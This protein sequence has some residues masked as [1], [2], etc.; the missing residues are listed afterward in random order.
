MKISV[1]NFGPIGEAKDIHLSPMTL[2]V[3]PSNTGKSYLAILLYAIAETF[4]RNLSWFTMAKKYLSDQDVM[5]KMI[6]DIEGLMSSH[7]KESDNSM[8]RKLYSDW[9]H[10]ISEIWREKILYCFGEEGENLLQN[11]NLSVILRSDD[12]TLLIDLVSPQHSRFLPRLQSEIIDKIPGILPPNFMQQQDPEK[13]R[14]FIVFGFIVGQFHTVL[15]DNPFLSAHYL[16]AIRGGIMQSHRGLV[17][18]TM[19]QAPFAGLL[20]HSPRTN[21][22]P[23][24]NGVL[25]DFVR[26]IIKVGSDEKHTSRNKNIAL[27]GER[28]EKGIMDGEIKIRKNETGYPDF[29]YKFS[30]GGKERELPL[31]NTSSMVSELAP[32]SVFVRHHLD[33]GDLFIVEEPEA[34]L[35]PKGQQAISDVL[36]QLANAGVFVLATTHSDIVLE[37]IGNAVRRAGLENKK[38]AAKNGGESLNENQAA[39]YSFAEGTK[40]KTKVKKIEFDSDE[41][42][43][44]DDHLEAS[45]ALYNETVELW[46]AN[47]D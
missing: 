22:A 35:H 17:D 21:T 4:T 24:F 33:K 20:G 18:A 42:F 12:E 1:K 28:M 5:L 7:A 27:I 32:I 26:D 10:T 15:L 39:A 30:R 14:V 41:G 19:A 8:F 25:S 11:K 31:N 40:G 38:S 23:M 13:E 37:Q 34:H 36:V 43:M 29:R 45:T 9:A 46:N 2:F 16:P 47:D 3:G 44:T 6:S